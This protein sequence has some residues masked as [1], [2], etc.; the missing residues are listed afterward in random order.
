MSAVLPV[1]GSAGPGLT[2]EQVHAGY[3]RVDVLRGC[4][5]NVAPG[6]AIAL[7]GPNGAG[8]STLFKVI[9]GL[10]P[11]RSGRVL[12]DGKVLRR[13]RANARARSGIVYV[14]EGRCVFTGLDVAENLELGAIALGYDS[15]AEDYEHVFRLFP[16]L[17]AKRQQ[18]AGTL[19]GGEQRMLAIAR[20]LIAQPR[21][22]LLD[23]PSLGLAPLLVQQLG[24]ACRT[25]VDEGLSII[26]A[27]Q[28]LG[29]VERMG[30]TVHLMTWGTVERRSDA[31]TVRADEKVAQAVLGAQLGEA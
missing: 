3:G 11:A 27:E 7:I 9:A 28:N 5:L 20:G 31:A 25:L 29:L 13:S 15:R 17:H 4:D 2:V 30:G 10:V 22:L 6:E 21:F 24:D 18:L 14:R 23:E 19:S 1:A 8:K 16:V 12:L 26:L